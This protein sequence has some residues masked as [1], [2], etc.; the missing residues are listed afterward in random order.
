MIN[1]EFA[2]LQFEEKT[3]SGCYRSTKRIIK[4]YKEFMVEKYPIDAKGVLKDDNGIIQY[5]DQIGIEQ[6]YDYIAQIIEKNILD[7]ISEE[8]IC[9]VAP[10]WDLLY[11]FSKEL[12]DRL[13]NVKFDAPDITPIKRDPMNIF[14]KLSRLLLTEPNIRQLT[15]R[16]KLANEIIEEISLMTGLPLAIE[17]LDLLNFIIQAKGLDTK[18]SKF[19]LNGIRYVFDAIQCRIDDYAELKKMY[20][21]FVEK[22]ESRLQNEKFQ[23]TDDLNTFKR[24]FK[25]KEGVVI[26]TCHGVK[27]EEYQTVIAFGL[28]YGKVPSIYTEYT[29]MDEEANKLLYVIA[30]RAKSR[31]YLFSEK[32]RQYKDNGLKKYV[33]A[34][35]T[36]QLAQNK[37]VEYDM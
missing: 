34:F 1:E 23:L 9:V 21:D 31:L 6:L 35:P 3:L 22:M 20:D 10:V 17:G 32:G 12:Q 25:E 37:S 8:E 4:Y 19:I 36:R 30:S 16:R 29:K 11:P 15:Y 5:N 2:D 7:G 18:G 14:Y 28:V 24:M 27:G 13:P 33:E 26:N